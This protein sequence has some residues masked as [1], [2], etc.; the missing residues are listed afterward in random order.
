MS[1][2]VGLNVGYALHQKNHLAQ[3]A[4]NCEKQDYTKEEKRVRVHAF[5]D[6]MKRKHLNCTV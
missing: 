5:L 1:S 3:L 4:K 2:V 6:E